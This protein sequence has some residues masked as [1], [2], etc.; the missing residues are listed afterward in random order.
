MEHVIFIFILGEIF[1]LTLYILIYF[2]VNPWFFPRRVTFFFVVS[3]FALITSIFFMLQLSWNSSGKYFYL[4]LLT[5]FSGIPFLKPKTSNSKWWYYRVKYSTFF[6]KFIF[7]GCLLYFRS[8]CC[9]SR[10]K[11]SWGDIN[12]IN[13]RLIFGGFYR[14]ILRMRYMWWVIY[15][16]PTGILIGIL[17]N[18]KSIRF[19]IFSSFLHELSEMT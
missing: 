7:F 12:N 2:Q 10:I 11:N 8:F 1:K 15:W 17:V 19:I 13:W 5:L 4:S 16:I 14:I 3:L 9:K 18:R 6:R